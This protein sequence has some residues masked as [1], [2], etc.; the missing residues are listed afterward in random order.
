MKTYRLSFT[1]PPPSHR[2]QFILAHIATGE[3]FILHENKE[4][5]WAFCEVGIRFEIK[6]GIRFSLLTFTLT[7]RFYERNRFTLYRSMIATVSNRVV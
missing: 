5:T 4:V 6:L 3:S 1:A 2:H 7:N